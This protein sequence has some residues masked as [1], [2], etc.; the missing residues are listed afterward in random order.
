[1]S[2]APNRRKLRNRKTLTVHKSSTA[3]S[4]L[5]IIHRFKYNHLA[6]DQAI[7]VR[8]ASAVPTETADGMEYPP[9][10]HGLAVAATKLVGPVPVI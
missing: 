5:I 10:L 2:F 4:T 9:T 3:A 8:A 7:A 6:D 1:M